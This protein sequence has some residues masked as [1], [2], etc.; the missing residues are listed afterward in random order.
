LIEVQDTGAGIDPQFLPH[1]FERFRQQD[2]TITRKHGGLGLGLSIVRHLT[3]L[4]GGTIDAHS[5]GKN[6]G[7]T[8]QIRL[9]LLE[10]YSVD[11]PPQSLTSH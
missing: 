11:Q 7:A 1:I 10:K 2:S 3:E 6:R 4:H 9:P 8:F 5:E